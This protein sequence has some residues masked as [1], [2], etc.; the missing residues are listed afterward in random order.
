[1][2]ARPT[3]ATQP[4]SLLQLPRGHTD[5]PTPRAQAN[6]NMCYHKSHYCYKSNLPQVPRNLKIL[7]SNRKLQRLRGSLTQTCTFLWNV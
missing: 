4:L 5:T 1:M 7:L 2:P 3:L 6:K